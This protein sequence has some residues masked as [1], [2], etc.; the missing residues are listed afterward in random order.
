MAN[1]SP[2][3]E[4][5]YILEGQK[6]NQQVESI[7]SDDGQ[8]LDDTRQLFVSEDHKPYSSL[9]L[10]SFNYINS[11]IG[12]GIIGIPYALHQAGFG[13]GLFLLILVA[14]A[15]DYSLVLMIRSGHLSGAFSYQG[16]MEAAFGKPGFILLSLLQFI[17]PFIAMVSYN[18][19]V[20]DTLTK[21][22]MRLAGAGA[23]SL[24]SHRKVV[25]ALATILIT[26]PLCLYRD[27]AKLAK[28]SFLSLVF[29][30]IILIAILLRLG[31]LH[32]TIPNTEDSWRFANWGIVPAI[33]IMA[34]AFMCH[35]NTFLLYDSIQDVDQHRWNTVTHASILISLVLSALFGMA[36]YA[37][38]TGNT[39]GDLLEN[40]CWHDDL[41][42]VSRIIFSITI[43]LTFPIECFVSREVIENSFFSHQTSPEDN[44]RTFRHVGITIFIVVT[45][46][47]ISMSTDCL[48]V[49]LELNGVL[50]AVPLAYVLPA[51]SY[52]K[53][54]EGSLLSHKKFPALC[55]AAFGII[56]AVLGIVMLITNSNK[57]DTCSHG[58]E[59]PYCLVYVTGKEILSG[60]KNYST[61]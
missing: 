12:S 23:D 18:V 4:G 7:S 19:A 59:P 34:F 13:I 54:E 39:Q 17:Y 15:T 56:I 48:G 24:L 51:V 9:P 25:V 28:V 47:L 30:I 32:G 1:K 16:L 31:T 40:Y 38:F 2:V 57:V 37:T 61:V 42:N 53:L 55:L 29:V 3:D 33:G 50:A 41:M 58:N 22:L 49:V 5:R 14:L 52:L 45:T 44:W 8:S 60:L 11:I 27:I 21:V 26:A 43:L 35:H 46:Y 20:G 10:A 6:G 36:G